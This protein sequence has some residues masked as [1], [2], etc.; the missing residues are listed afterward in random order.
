MP[1]R[2]SDAARAVVADASAEAAQRGY[3]EVEP[4]HLLVAVAGTRD[5]VVQSAMDAC[6][7]AQAHLRLV[8]P[9]NRSRASRGSHR[10]AFAEET[11][12]IL[13]GALREA[14]GAGEQAVEPH[15]MLLALT[16][17][18]HSQVNRILH[19]TGVSC[20]QLRSTILEH[21]SSDIGPVA[22]SNAMELECLRDLF[23]SLYDVVAGLPALV[24]AELDRPADEGDLILGLAAPDGLVGRALLRLGVT[25]SALRDALDAERE[26]LAGAT[27]EATHLTRLGVRPAD[28]TAAM[29]DAA[30]VGD[31][32]RSAAKGRDPPVGGLHKGRCGPPDAPNVRR[33]SNA[34]DRR[35]RRVILFVATRPASKAQPTG[36]QQ[37]RS[38]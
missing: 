6:G 19:H 9:P 24:R 2:F 37:G 38:F 26:A 13:A 27:D 1:E 4:Q 3:V 25:V 29:A 23:G 11:K 17:A 34:S 18:G 32:D 14:L 7:I 8:E 20:D 35:R 5:A 10:L 31:Y 30:D 16:Q 36:R 33:C 28:L 22:M 21:L 15:H 12:D